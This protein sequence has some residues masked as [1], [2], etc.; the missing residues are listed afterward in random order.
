MKRLFFSITT[1]IA[2]L[3]IIVPVSAIET[4]KD[5]L[6]KIH[7]NIIKDYPQIPHISRKELQSRL[8]LPSNNLLILDTRPIKEYDVSHIEGAIQINPNTTPQEFEE[9]F[10]NQLSGKTIIVYCSVGR[11]S[12]QLGDRLTPIISRSEA[13]QFYNLEGGLFSWHND[14]RKLVNASGNTDAIHP[15]N[16]FWG[17]LIQNKGQISYIPK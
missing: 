13:V 8:A 6:V 9:Q 5:P 7:A 12:T 4:A 1:S 14:R 11:R 10:G 17:R 16:L 15:Y 2:L 3:C